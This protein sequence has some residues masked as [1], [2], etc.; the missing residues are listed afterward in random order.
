MLE[1][2][3]RKTMQTD[4]HGK[5]NMSDKSKWNAKTFFNCSNNPKEG[6]RGKQEQQR[7][8]TENK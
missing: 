6:R 2:P 1:Q 4:R 7:G 3:L 8:V 5:K